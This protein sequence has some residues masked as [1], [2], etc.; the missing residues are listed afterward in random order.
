MI[1]AT[2]ECPRSLFRSLQDALT[3]A[4]QEMSAVLEVCHTQVTRRRCDRNATCNI[5]RLPRTRLHVWTLSASQLSAELWTREHFKFSDID[6][7]FP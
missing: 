5:E 4:D 2:E 6:V 1:E 7:T 3:I